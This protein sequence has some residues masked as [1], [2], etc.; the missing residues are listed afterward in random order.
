[1]IQSVRFQNFKVLRDCTLPLGQF[2]LLVGPNG[3]GKTTAIQGLRALWHRGEVLFDRF[4][5]AGVEAKGSVICVELKWD[6]SRKESVTAARWLH[7][8][9]G[10][11][12]HRRLGKPVEPGLGSSL[13]ATLRDLR[14]YN[15]DAQAIAQAVKLEPQ[16]ELSPGGGRL[17]GVLDRLR[18][19]HPERFEGI[20]AELSRW[21]PE[22]DRILFDTPSEGSRAVALRTARGG[23]KIA[24]ADISQGTLLA[25]AILTLAYIAD[26]PPVVCFEEP[27]R[28][29]HPRLLRD[30]RDAL[31]RLAHPDS[32]GEKR[33]AV[34]VI[35]TTH[36]PYF[37]DLF[38]EHPEEIVICEELQDNVRF[39][40]LSDREDLEEILGSA[41]LGDAW[42]SGVLGGVPT[43]R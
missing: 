42:Y 15:L 17:A 28:G 27:G 16:M 34:Q 31:Y 41:H 12:D 5:S 4:L 21:L 38:R 33:P 37:L 22:F 32:A 10:R 36:N 40:R 1:M 23:H 30:V 18:D 39:Q 8:R 24:A 35:A 6:P 11:L 7:G 19:E 2:T 20:N 9:G 13:D 25:L 26:P 29:L 43:D 14:C 3:S